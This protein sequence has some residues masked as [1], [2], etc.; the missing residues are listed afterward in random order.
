MELQDG[1]YLEE[2]EIERLVEVKTLISQLNIKTN[3]LSNHISNTVPITG[4]LP[5]DKALILRELD[6]AI[7]DF[8]EEQLKAYRSRVWH[9]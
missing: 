1:I 7:S 2:P 6:K 3:I 8:P 5:K 4:V 9:L